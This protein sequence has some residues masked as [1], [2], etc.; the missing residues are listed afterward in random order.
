MRKRRLLGLLLSVAMIVPVLSSCGESGSVENK[1]TIN[2]KQTSEK[3]SGEEET[4]KPEDDKKDESVGLMLY[5]DMEVSADNDKQLVDKSGQGNDGS[6]Y[7]TYDIDDGVLFLENGGYVEIPKGTFDG[8]NTLTISLWLNNYTG[9]GNYSAMFIGTTE[10]MP[11]SYWLLN[12]CNPAGV[13][14][15]VMTNS[16]NASAPYKTE[17]GISASSGS[18][19]T[20]PTT[21]I[22]WAMYTTV[23]TEESITAY[24]NGQ[25]VGTQEVKRTISDFGDDLVSYLGKSSYDDPPYAGFIKE[26]KVYDKELTADEIKAEYEAMEKAESDYS[27]SEYANP[28]IE[29]RADPYIVKGNDGYYYFTASYPMRG[30]KDKDGYDRVILRRSTT[31][32]GLATAEEITIWDENQS[33]EVDCYI[34]APEM[35]YIGG[36]WY[37]YFAGSASKDNVFDV[38]CQV[39]QCDSADPYTGNWTLKGMFEGVEG[40]DFSFSFFSLDMTY[41]ENNGEHYVIWAQKPGDSNLY[42]ATI[43]PDEPWKLTSKPITL[44]KPEYYWEKVRYSVCEGPSVLKHDGKVFVCYSA[45]GTG[46]EYCVGLLTA[47]ASSD[48]MD[49]KSWTKSDKPILTSEDL[50]QEYGPGHNSFT[51]DEN[52]DYVFVYH[53]RSQECFDGDCGFAGQDPLVDPCRHARLRKVLWAEDGT[54]IL[55]GVAE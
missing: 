5:Y 25:L 38:R 44:V 23:I 27:E 33:D 54:P 14:K 11:I 13:M 48:L 10:S 12:P 6:L 32:E 9:A 15:S 28:F 22:G 19:I 29:E 8:K 3:Q 26:V 7:G 52:G 51:V 17:V 39:L 53:A 4:K 49:I 16:A 42:M 35:H 50:Y 40:D 55:N 30:S 46:P 1:T 24:Y 36:K 47:D 31:L 2:E 20:G 37:V 45:A 21:G 18:T 34:W 43:N 41:F